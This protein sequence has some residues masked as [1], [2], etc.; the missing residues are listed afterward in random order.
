MSRGRHAKPVT[1]DEEKAIVLC[2]QRGDGIHKIGKTFGRCANKTIREIADKHGLRPKR[3]RW[4]A[5]Q[6]AVLRPNYA[7]T[8]THELARMLRRT[9]LSVYQ[10]AQNLGLKKSAAYLAEKL[11]LEGERLKVVGR[12]SRFVKGLVPANKGLRRPGYSVG[13]G[14]MRETQFKKGQRSGVAVDLYKP[15]GTERISKDGY[16]ERKINDGLPL[17]RRWRAVHLIM[18]E[19]VNGPLPRGHAIAFKNGNRTDLRLENFELIPRR[20]LMRRNS[21]HNLPPELKEVIQLKGT[22]NSVIT[23][24][25]K[26]TNVHGTDRKRRS[27]HQRTAIASVRND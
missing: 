6:D 18:W 23:K 21:I 7:D 27:K 10:R 11:R 25:E 26:K 1:P 2:L 9:E 24:K 8:D 16:L 5:S 4:T 13:R 20:E 3:E 22:L 19:E 14:R 15:I 12:A 17:Q